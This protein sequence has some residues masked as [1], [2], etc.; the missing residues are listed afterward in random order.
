[1]PNV[2]PFVRKFCL[3]VAGQGDISVLTV[4]DEQTYAESWMPVSVYLRTSD[5]DELRQVLAYCKKRWPDEK[6]AQFVDHTEDGS[7]AR[8]QL[9]HL[10]NAAK[11]NLVRIVVIQNYSHLATTTHGIAEAVATLK[12]AGAELVSIDDNLDTGTPW[13]GLLAEMMTLIATVPP[14]YIRTWTANQLK[15]REH[16]KR[17]GRPRKYDLET[18]NEALAMY[19]SGKYTLRELAEMVSIPHTTLHTC[20]QQQQRKRLEA[21]EQVAS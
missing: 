5:A 12:R 8:P 14:Q 9:R 16:K 20:W 19:A 4:P 13:G 17:P 3:T 11:M 1:M 2:I 18:I 21:L 6:I 15:T 10:Y 7:H